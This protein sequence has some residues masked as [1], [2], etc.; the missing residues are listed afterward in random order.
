[1]R[2]R[3]G[4]LS[5]NESYVLRPSVLSAALAAAGVAIDTHL[6]RNP[7][8]LFAAN[9][10]PPSADVPY[11]RLYV[12]AGSVPRERAAAVRRHVEDVV[13]PH[14]VAWIADILSRDG[15]SPVRREQQAIGFTLP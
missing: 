6:V 12:Q 10:W 3:T 1:M 2:S 4:K 9:F 8:P 5:K 14:I 7:G 13:V 11:E 15:A